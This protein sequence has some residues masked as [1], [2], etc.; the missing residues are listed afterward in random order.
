VHGC[1]LLIHDRA[2]KHHWLFHVLVHQHASSRTHTR[3]MSAKR[4]NVFSQGRPE[5]P[6]EDRDGPPDPP[7]RA[8]AAQLAARKYV[9]LHRPPSPSAFTV[10]LH[11]PTST[12]P[13]ACAC[14]STAN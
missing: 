8:T 2:P 4:A 3:D 14:A 10:R 13:F 11:R 9:H 12:V 7:K 1:S 5:N 6:Y